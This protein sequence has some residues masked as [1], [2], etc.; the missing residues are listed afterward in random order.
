MGT[1]FHLHATLKS[2]VHKTKSY[3][4][5]IIIVLE[6]GVR[7]YEM[8]IIVARNQGEVCLL[9]NVLSREVDSLLGS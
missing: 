8:F 6:I 9:V 2:H 7:Y 1:S 5:R 3:I 4:R